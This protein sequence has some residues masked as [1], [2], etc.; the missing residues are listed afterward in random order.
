MKI[1]TSYWGNLR[2]L[3]N[4]GI[5]P[6]A[7]SRG[8]PKNW[9]G[10][11]YDKL[12]PTW[13][14]LKMD[15]AQYDILYAKILEQNNQRIFE[16]WLEKNIKPGCKDVALLCWEKNPNDCHRSKVAEWLRSAGI[17]CDEFVGQQKVK[18]H[19]PALTQMSFF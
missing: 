9:Q 12:A 2:K 17:E 1:Y 5:E 19:Q 15:E 4:A 8:K 10:R 11:S 18:H 3:I 6:V 16:N 14:M 7:I 13:D